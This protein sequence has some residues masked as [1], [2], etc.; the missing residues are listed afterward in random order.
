MDHTSTP[1]SA[2]PKP[3]SQPNSGLRFAFAP[4]A[5]TPSRSIAVPMISQSRFAPDF[6]MA[7]AVQKMPSFAPLSSVTSQCGRY[8]SHTSTAPRNAPAI[9]APR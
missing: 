7:G 8:A 3:L 9:C 5:S 6:R 2:G 1:T 4:M